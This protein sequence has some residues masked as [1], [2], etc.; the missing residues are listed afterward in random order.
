MPRCIACST[1]SDLP[2]PP[3][4]PPPSARVGAPVRQEP[5]QAPLNQADDSPPLLRLDLLTS[6][7]LVPLEFSLILPPR[8]QRVL[9]PLCGKSLDLPYLA[10]LGHSVGGVECVT[11]ALL[12]FIQVGTE[13]MVFV[14]VP[15]ALTWPVYFYSHLELCSRLF[16]ELIQLRAGGGRVAS[17]AVYVCGGGGG[18]APG[19]RA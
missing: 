8:P 7:H 16:R 13:T 2:P 14:S 12:E 5:P 18:S 11:Q 9:V 19:A 6:L 17:V 3:P 4:A 10:G 1:L 15:G